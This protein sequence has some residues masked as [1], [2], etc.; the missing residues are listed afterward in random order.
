MAVGDFVVVLLCLLP[1]ALAGEWKLVNTTGPAPHA[2][3]DH[4]LGTLQ[5]GNTA[6]L[7]GGWSGSGQF[8]NDTWTIDFTDEKELFWKE[9]ETADLVATNSRA[10][11]TLSVVDPSGNFGSRLVVWAGGGYPSDILYNSI[12][13]L[14]LDTTVW[15]NVSVKNDFL[16]PAMM[17]QSSVLTSD[18]R[19]ISFGGDTN[20]GTTNAVWVYALNTST[21]TQIVISGSQPKPRLWHT[22]SLYNDK[23]MYVF[24]GKTAESGNCFG[25]TWMLNL[26]SWTWTE[27]STT[28]PAK[29]SGH[30]AEIYKNSLFVFAGQG[31]TGLT[32]Y[33][34]LW[35]FDLTTNT[36]TEL[37]PTGSLPTPVVGGKS[38]VVHDSIM[39]VWSGCTSNLNG[40][41]A[42]TPDLW[43]YDLA[44]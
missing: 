10:D 7:F 26:S 38:T 13:A 9:L 15:S 33:N 29:R 2:R 44:Q 28:G 16:P 8:L 20:S 18:G 34:D 36:W 39:V 32:M 14:D 24:G 42:F 40:C 11:H 31:D 25:D 17:G 6:V 35:A 30:V 22:A 1:F 23:Y 37:F 3:M 43:T 41:T 21:W 19:I 4:T 5:D 12:I 27:L